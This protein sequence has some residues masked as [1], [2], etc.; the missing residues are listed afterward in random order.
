MMNMRTARASEIPPSV[1]FKLARMILV[2]VLPL[3]AIFTFLIDLSYTRERAQMESEAIEVARSMSQAVDRELSSIQMAAE[4]LSTSPHLQHGDI[5]AFYTQ[6]REV[7]RRGIGGRNVVLSDETGQEVINTRVPLGERLPVRASLDKLRQVFATGKPV[8]SDLF[9]GRVSRRPIINVDVPVFRGKE[10]IYSLSM[11]F[12]PEHFAALL[13]RG[14]IA[15]IYDSQGVIVSSNIA[16]EKYMGSSAPPL[17]LGRMR[18][19]PEGILE[20]ENASGTPIVVAFHR[21]EMSRWMM[22]VGIEKQ[23]LYAGSIQSLLWISL[24]TVA[25]LALGLTRAWIV[26]NGISRPIRSLAAPAL[27]LGA[28]RPVSIPALHLK[29]AEEVASALRQAYALLQERTAERDHAKELTLRDGLTGV[30]NRR[31]FDET[32]EREW[33]RCERSG[34]PIALIM[35][36]IDYFKK[37]NDQYGHQDGDA[38]IKSVAVILSRSV[39]RPSD[40]VARYG[41]EEFAVLLPEVTLEGAKVVAGRILDAVRA[42]AIP[43]AKSPIATR[44]VTVSLGVTAYIPAPGTGLPKALLREAD[45]YLYA[46][47][48]AGRN[49]LCCGPQHD[50]PVL[51]LKVVSGTS[52]SP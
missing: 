25:L 40:L 18:E 30:A 37:F 28:G 7:V 39:R 50:R 35:I 16:P 9:V 2:C 29:E 31:C 15:N 38:C 41:G 4:V 46:A 44:I 6:A 17:L 27:A 33:Q 12:L 24:G 49:Q 10:I 23:L 43:H 36:D 42:A 13:P 51:G 32:L 21:S 11:S 5:A 22:S 1:R 52:P 14:W 34:R 26:G 48:S 45:A 19:V 3:V 47:K 8:M 20:T